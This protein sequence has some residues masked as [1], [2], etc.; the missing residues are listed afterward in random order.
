[1][2]FNPLAAGVRAVRLP[3]LTPVNSIRTI[4]CLFPLPVS[5]DQRRESMASDRFKIGVGRRDPRRF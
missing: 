2:K 3:W 1:M 5:T 4:H